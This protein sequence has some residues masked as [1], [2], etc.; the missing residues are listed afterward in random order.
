MKHIARV[1]VCSSDLFWAPGGRTSRGRT[2]GRQHS[3]LYLRGAGSKTSQPPP[4]ECYWYILRTKNTSPLKVVSTWRTDATGK[5][6]EKSR[7]SRRSAACM[8]LSQ[9]PLKFLPRTMFSQLRH[10]R[11]HK[12]L[13][14][15]AVDS[16]GVQVV[17]TTP[18]SCRWVEGFFCCPSTAH[19]TMSWI[20]IIM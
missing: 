14:V 5:R 8:C 16:A 4:A 3:T 9:A 17:L 19:T 11:H 18:T 20:I 7:D 10:I 2:G 12:K 13:S 1:R 6:A 15:L